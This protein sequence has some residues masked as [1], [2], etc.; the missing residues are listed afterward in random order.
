MKKASIFTRAVHADRSSDEPALSV[1]I[2]NASIFELPNSEDGSAIHNHQK[3]GH[4]YGRLGNPT[5]DAL[6]IA[7]A[8]LENAEAALSFASGMA[9]ISAILFSF[10]KIGDHIIAP[11]SIYST[12]SRLIKHYVD[13]FGIEATFIDP[14]NANNFRD[15]TKSNT[16]LIWIETPSNPTLSITDIAAVSKISKDSNSISVVDNTFATPFN[17]N[18][19]DLGVSCV[20]HSATKYLGGHSDLN[21]G[22]IAGKEECISTIFDNA[23]KLIGGAIAPQT[24]WLL[25]RGIK[26]LAIRL[27]QQN[28]NAFALA[29]MLSEDA[30]IGEVHYPGL[31]SHPNHK[32][33][34]QQM[35]E[36]GAMLAID[37]GSDL[38]AKKFCDSLELFTLATSLG[39]VESIVQHSASMT[40]ATVSQNE[41]DV[42]GVTDGL[43]RLSV[44]I[45][46]LEDL[47]DDISQALNRV[48]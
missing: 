22:V 35:R 31:E 42:A 16:N 13:N 46:D 6:N 10:L 7:T 5:Q 45:E 15:A 4:F 19:L 34:N 3:P 24:A 43:I 38:R 14:T 23:G 27:K 25:M 32:I 17:Q 21:A 29:N 11:N 41:R 44:G 20:V 9:A 2:Y 28:K 36:Y 48:S 47:Q 30:R 12:S 18:P 33:A 39:G 8:N 26:T 40:H 1:P 37:L